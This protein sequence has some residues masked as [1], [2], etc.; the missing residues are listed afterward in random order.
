MRM[1]AMASMLALMLAGCGGD[2][3]GGGTTAASPTGGATPTPTPSPVAT[4][5]PAPTPTPTDVTVVTEAPVASFDNPWAMVFLPDGRLLVTE[6]PG[7]LQL[8]TQ[9]GVKTQVGGVPAVT[10]AGQLGLQDVVLAPDYATTGRIYLSYAEPAAG[11]Q[12]LAVARATLS[13]NGAPALTNL[14]VVWRATPTTTGGQL[15]GRIA[16]SS[17][18]YM[19]VSSGERQQ[20]TPAQDLSGTLG[21]IVR[22]NPDGTT[23][24]GN[25]FAAT[26][27]TRAEI[28]S[29]GHR[30]PYGLVFAADG[31][32][33][34]SEMGPAGGDEFNLIASGRNYGWPNVSDGDNYD[35]SAIPRH[36]TNTT[37][38]APLV[39]WTPV[40]APGGMIQYRGTRFTGWTGDFVLAGLTQ[41]GLVRVR[42]AGS[43]A[44][45]VAR[46]SLGARIREVEEGPD[47]AI[48]V[49]EDGSSG[50]LIRLDPAATL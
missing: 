18:G 25:P 30:N 16:F 36:A 24:A 26:A 37:Y 47:G 19:F 2:G 45:Q 22:L 10:Y 20:G 1:T 29:L 38:V 12:R 15:G 28:W 4:A 5:T 31:R 13:L 8:V 7:R 39:S 40:I 48:W 43:T 33:F 32:L 9:A 50:R 42:V 11:G 41:Q 14:A 44:T 35:G 6:K 17:D 23:P 34:E 46:L 21:K 27:G 49:L 3:A